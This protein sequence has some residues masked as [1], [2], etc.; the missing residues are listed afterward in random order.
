[1]GFG[2]FDPYILSLQEK[3]DAVR[4][5]QSRRIGQEQ[6]QGRQRPG[7]HHIIGFGGQILDPRVLY[8]NGQSHAFCGGAEEY[9]FLRGGFMQGHG[10]IRSHRR[11]HQPGKP[12]ARPEIG[13]SA[14]SC[15]DKGFQLGGIQEVPLPKVGHGA[16]GHQIV[17]GV[18]F[19][20]QVGIGLQPRQCF[21]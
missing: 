6:G 12:S 14:Y 3:T 20:Q 5:A 17:P 8:G 18:P 21:T 4:A 10:D 11:Q 7:R 9:A 19:D 13:Q 2:Q 15:R 1:M 16:S